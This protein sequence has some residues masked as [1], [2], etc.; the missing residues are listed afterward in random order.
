MPT[1]LKNIEECKYENETET[2][3]TIAAADITGIF[4]IF[5]SGESQVCCYI[6]ESINLRFYFNVLC[7][8][9]ITSTY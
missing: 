2:N 7:D 4:L 8:V 9:I 1:L 3:K 6:D 5:E